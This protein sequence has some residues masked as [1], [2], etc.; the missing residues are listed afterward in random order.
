MHNF[1]ESFVLIVDMEGP[2][3]LWLSELPDGLVSRFRNS[4]SQSLSGPS[5]L[6]TNKKGHLP[7]LRDAFLNVTFT[8]KRNER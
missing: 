7:N 3:R 8:M 1:L 4:D 6:P 2:D 5:A